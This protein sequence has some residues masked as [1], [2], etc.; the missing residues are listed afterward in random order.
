MTSGLAGPATRPT[1]RVS[2]LLAGAALTLLLTA[3]TA[4]ATGTGAPKDVKAPVIS[5]K[6][7]D[8]ATVAATAGI[9]EGSAT[10]TFAYKWQRCNSAGEASSCADIPGAISHKYKL[11]HADVGSTVRA[12]V[13][14]TN[15]EGSSG[16]AS[17]PSAVV[18]PSKPAHV[19]VPTV[20][21]IPTDGKLVTAGNGTWKGTPPFTYS[22]QWKE[23][24]KTT[25]TTVAGATE[26]S[27]RPT[28][29][30]IKKQLRVTVT[31]HNS[32][33]SASG[34]SALA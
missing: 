30:Q 22:Y 11:Q 14:A 13:T 31:A 32:V 26:Q 5:G 15:G 19:K 18:Q 4:L 23:C 27:Y 16:A 29:A 33:G 6:F 21:G 2:K 34:T 20:P 12:I 3:P 7:V 17:K 24:F 10:I 25:C 8:E 28:T 9:W 1:T